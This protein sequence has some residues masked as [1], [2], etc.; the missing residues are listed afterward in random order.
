MATLDEDL[1]GEKDWRLFI[2]DN[3]YEYIP[4][5]RKFK[6]RGFHL[7]FNI[8]VLFLNVLWML[9]RK[10]FLLTAIVFAIWLVSLVGIILALEALGIYSGSVGFFV[11]CGLLLG[12][13]FVGDWLYYLHSTKKI[14]QVRQEYHNSESYKDELVKAGG[15]GGVGLLAFLFVIIVGVCLFLI[16][17]SNAL[18][19]A[20]K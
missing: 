16:A 3:Y 4:K 8:A 5:W 20:W 18:G 7:F 10:M 2:G 14:A 19:G 17:L 13:G 12:V 15:A 11:N 1:A 6:A 9:T